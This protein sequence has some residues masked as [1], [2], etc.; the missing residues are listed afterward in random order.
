MPCLE[1]WV[2]T[3][4]STLVCL[5]KRSVAH[6]QKNHPHILEGTHERP[7]ITSS[8]DLLS[9]GMKKSPTRLYLHSVTLPSS[10]Y[11]IAHNLLRAPALCLAALTCSQRTFQDSAAIS[12]HVT[13]PLQ[14]SAM[15][16][17]PQVIIRPESRLSPQA[18][19]SIWGE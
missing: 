19:N 3:R 16:A 1:H 7:Q 6:S 4:G 14:K 17:S 18:K 5:Q 9:T 10:L 12:V 11:T 8:R 2:T 15:T 13:K